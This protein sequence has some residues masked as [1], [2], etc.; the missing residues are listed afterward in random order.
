[1]RSL[2][3]ITGIFFILVI[4]STCRE[5]DHLE[6]YPP[7]SVQRA[8]LNSKP[9]VQSPRILDSLLLTRMLFSLSAD[10][11]EGREPG[12]EGH[13][14]A[15]RIISAEMRT[16]GLD[17]FE[18]SLE[19]IFPAAQNNQVVTAKNLV[20]W[21]KGSVFPDQFIV[22]TAH[23]DHLGKNAAGQ[24]Y[25]G[26]DDN[27]SGVGV[28]VAL[29]KYFKAN[30]HPYS[31][32]FVACDIEESA[33][34]GSFYFVKRMREKN[35]LEQVVLNINLDMV[36]RSDNDEL[37]ICGVRY[38][39]TLRTLVESTQA[40]LNV[41]LLMWHDDAG[42]G[43][44]WTNLSDHYPFHEVRIP[45]LYLGV[46]DHADYHQPTDRADKIDL[47]RYVE[48]ANAA[49]VLLLQARNQ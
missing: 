2:L 23:Y 10:S 25:S 3:T 37:F 14:R 45:F 8:A 24:I 36:A 49:A 30:P 40:L 17:S 27:A 7:L 29:A 41:K 26:A 19:Q 9:R 20:G 22:V 44:N 33:L 47:S 38:N 13:R 48:N 12:S 39:P 15:Q 16:L 46:E 1:M 28:L 6:P 18:N 35:L 21:I 42:Q 5:P 43:G 32:I 31:L 34:Q 4:F 11:C